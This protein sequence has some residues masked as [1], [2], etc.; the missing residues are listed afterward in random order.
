MAEDTTPQSPPDWM[1]PAWVPSSTGGYMKVAPLATMDQMMAAKPDELSKSSGSMM[2]KLMAT[3]VDEQIKQQ[4]EQQYSD[5]GELRAP[6]KDEMI[7]MAWE[8]HT[9]GLFSSGPR[10]RPPH[11]EGVKTEW[12][13]LPHMVG[14]LVSEMALQPGNIL[15]ATTAR[16]VPAAA[17]TIIRGYAGY[18]LAQT[19]RQAKGLY[20]ELQNPDVTGAQ[21]TFDTFAYSLQTI[22]GLALGKGPTKMKFETGISDLQTATKVMPTEEAN[23]L[24][25]EMHGKSPTELAEILQR[26]AA[27]AKT[28]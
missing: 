15:A 4:A 1:T 14:G 5:P 8:Q 11:D 2:D 21:K 26:K 22:L 20:G 17:S 23:Q 16:A 13:D 7:A 12:S 3:P 27:E 24:I 28:L 10:S 6:T 19:L 25:Q 18:M 9:G